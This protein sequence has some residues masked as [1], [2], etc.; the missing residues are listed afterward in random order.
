VFP[1]WSTDSRR[2]IFKARG[3]GN[4][5]T[6][7]SVPVSGGTPHLL[8]R[9]DDPARPSLRIEFTTD[10]ETLFFTIGTQESDVWVMDLESG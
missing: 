9:L 3:P 2:V 4:T 8:A 10:G 6:F 5:G 1:E 7:W